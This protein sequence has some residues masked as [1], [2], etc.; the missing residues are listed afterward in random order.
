V[1]VEGDAGGDVDEGQ[2]VAVVLGGAGGRWHEDGFSGRG[3]AP[4]VMRLDR[5]GG[6]IM[7]EQGGRLRVRRPH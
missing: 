3:V 6:Q 1:E 4:E 2:E 5:S 7:L